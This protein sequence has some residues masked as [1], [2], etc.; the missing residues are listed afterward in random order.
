[1]WCWLALSEESEFAVLREPSALPSLG[2][3][4][5]KGGVQLLSPVLLCQE[6]EVWLLVLGAR[7]PTD[8]RR[9]DSQQRGLGA[10]RHPDT[11]AHVH[12]HRDG[13]FLPPLGSSVSLQ[14]WS[15]FSKGN[16]DGWLLG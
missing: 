3:W 6:L 5:A 1:M 11:Q 9:T 14:L 4:D 15:L 7:L 13:H 12:C 16:C 2:E 8:I 10:R